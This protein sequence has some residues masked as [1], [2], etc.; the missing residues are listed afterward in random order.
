[1]LRPLLLGQFYRL[2]GCNLQSGILF[3]LSGKGE[4]QKETDS[5][6]IFSQ[7]EIENYTTYYFSFPLQMSSTRNIHSQSK[8]CNNLRY[9][10]EQLKLSSDKETYTKMV[11]SLVVGLANIKVAD[12]ETILWINSDI[13]NKSKKK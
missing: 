13:F 12:I 2:T 4:K 7:V 11:D 8:I 9:S 5:R 10:L 6:Y 3:S 1:M